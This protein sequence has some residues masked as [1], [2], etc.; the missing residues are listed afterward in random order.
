MIVDDEYIYQAQSTNYKCYHA[1][2]TKGN[3][4]SIGIEIC[5]FNDKERQLKAYRNAIELVKILMAYHK[6]DVSKVIRH[7]DWTKKDCP[8]WLI[9][10]K[11]GY[12]WNWFK[13]ELVGKTQQPI[14]ETKKEFLVKV[15]YQGKEGL[16][17]R[18]EP[19]ATSKIKGQVFFNQVFTI[20]EEKNGWG[21][22]KSGV[23][24]ISLNAKYIKRM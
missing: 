18:Q 7:Y 2:C 5:M 22:L 1:G 17:I 4:S 16:N 10:G 11:W 13:N 19:N 21:K 14:N 24:W 3:N 15:I 20:V 6:F 12:N 8:T 9:S 23:G